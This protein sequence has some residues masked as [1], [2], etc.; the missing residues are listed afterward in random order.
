MTKRYVKIETPEG[1]KYL[2]VVVVYGR[3]RV[4]HAHACDTASEAEL[5]SAVIQALQNAREKAALKRQKDN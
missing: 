1:K 3:R 4:L 2:P 5:R